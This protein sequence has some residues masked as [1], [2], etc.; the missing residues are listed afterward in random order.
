M[1]ES[2]AGADGVRMHSRAAAV[3]VVPVG[4]GVAVGALVGSASVAAL[5][6]AAVLTGIYVWRNYVIPSRP[7]PRDLRPPRE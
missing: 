1:D 7:P 5:T 4:V 3:V 2:H 6:A